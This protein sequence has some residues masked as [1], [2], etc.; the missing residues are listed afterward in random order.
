MHHNIYTR[1][2]QKDFILNS[3]VAI[4]TFNKIIIILIY[5]D[6]T[7][8]KWQSLYSEIIQIYSILKLFIINRSGK[9]TDLKS[10][11]L[12]KDSHFGTMAKGAM[13]WMENHEFQ[14]HLRYKDSKV[15][16]V[17][18]FLLTLGR[19]NG[20]PLLKNVAKKTE[21]ICPAVNKNQ[22]LFKGTKN[23]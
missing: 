12:N 1:N 14:F 6:L 13:L 5:I 19:S 15:T 4:Y 23:Y 11:K 20:E 9:D 18:W 2:I 10:L 21:R 7:L 22:D 17:L 3:E 8:L 16:L